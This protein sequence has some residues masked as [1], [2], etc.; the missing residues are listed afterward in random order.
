MIHRYKV[1]MD[2]RPESIKLLEKKIGEY[3]HDFVIRKIFKLEKKKPTLTIRGK[4]GKLDFIQ[5]F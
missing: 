3:L 2:F 1:K 4:N 5:I